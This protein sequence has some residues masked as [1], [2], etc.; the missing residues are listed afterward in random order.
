MVTG[1]AAERSAAISVLKALGFTYTAA[2]KLYGA[3]EDEAVDIVRGDPYRAAIEIPGIGFKTADAVAASLASGAGGGAVGLTGADGA[4][5]ASSSIP[6]ASADRFARRAAAGILYIL[7]RYASEGHTCVPR[8]K[9][10]DRAVELLDV[11]ADD[12]EDSLFELF[13]DGRASEASVC[14]SPHIFLT[15][16]FLAER[17]ICAG[18]MRL[19]LSEP[20]RLYADP[21]DLIGRT[22]ASLG[23]KLSEE[24]RAAVS[25][26]LGSGVFVVTGGPGTGKTTI[27]KA[28]IDIFEHAGLK[29]AVAAPTGRA[30]RRVTEAT[31]HRASTIHRL[32]EYYYD[33]AA[34]EMYFGRN[35]NN[36]LDYEAVI[37]DEASMVD[38]VLMEALL[39]A[40]RTGARL[41]IV[42]DA[43]QLPPVGA[44][45]VL[46]DILESE[47]A[48]HAVLT[49]IYRQ[50][51]ESMIVV[52]AHRI[53]RGEY[54]EANAEGA[55]FIMRERQSGAEALKEVIRICSGGPPGASDVPG[56]SD[57][58]AAPDSFP[59]VAPV[60]PVR[61]F[62]VP[63]FASAG[64]VP[65]VQVLSPMKKGML[66]CENL[67]KELQAAL[68]PPAPQKA[69][70]KYG[71][72][73]FREG[74]RIMQTR[75]N[76]SLEWTDSSDG[77]EGRGVFN[78]DIGVVREIDESSGVVTV[79]YDDTK[80]VSYA[81][82]GLMEIEHAYA[83]TVHKSQGSEFPV[84]VIPVYAAAPP[85]MTRN[86]IYT[87]VTRGKNVVV[88]VGSM[89]RLRQMIDNDKG[90][91]R[92]S[93]LKSFLIEYAEAIDGS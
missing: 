85:L 53:D 60:G 86:L 74:D 81:V 61:V 64:S 39:E 7:T 71:D 55:D 76:Y 49:E 48:P 41:I 56:A 47:R 10:I 8:R 73:V 37:I 9:L 87:A 82:D 26:S 18:L 1:A 3:Y 51:A 33:E 91:T 46:R 45:D 36:R 34:R 38:V 31:G 89:D 63:A 92:Y 88:L 80:Y 24:Q 20:K 13:L 23:I 58:P 69:E 28:V 65:A 67:N 68:N 11:T 62:G 54:P 70:R 83:I 43:D 15:R 44:G 77:S 32:L 6:A 57:R 35:A 59:A 27:I 25:D 40:L 66:G 42:G 14:G 79:A 29:T 84:V 16:Y 5:G 19:M 75:N 72:R 21:G 50:A 22:E 17:T 93:G 90:L 2:V 30:A 78:G 52:N 4:A 12:V